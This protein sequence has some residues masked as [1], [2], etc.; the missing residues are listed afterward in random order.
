[1]VK[2]NKIFSQTN[3][4]TEN[5]FFM[6]TTHE[7]QQETTKTS[8][9]LKITLLNSSQLEL[10]VSAET[11]IQD[12]YQAV[13]DSTRIDYYTCFNIQFNSQ[14]LSLGSTLADVGITGTTTLELCPMDYNNHQLRVHLTKFREI[15]SGYTSSYRNHGNAHS[16]SFLS[17]FLSGYG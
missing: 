13:F 5:S 10:L 16:E 7:T 3:H 9:P 14:V 17:S 11:C 8:F 1:M 2:S 4:V 6:A 12:I 15:L